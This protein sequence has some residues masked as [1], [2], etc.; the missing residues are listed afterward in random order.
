MS[1]YLPKFQLVKLFPLLHQFTNKNPV[2]LLLFNHSINMHIVVIYL[3]IFL[4]KYWY[5]YNLLTFMPNAMSY[6]QPQMP[7]LCLSGASIGMMLIFYLQIW[8]LLFTDL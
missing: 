5:I 3:L 7:I 1:I 6:Q 2:C 4:S 8:L